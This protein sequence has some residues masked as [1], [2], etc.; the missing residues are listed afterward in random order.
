MRRR[1]DTVY[2]KVSPDFVRGG[3]PG[4]NFVNEGTIQKDSFGLPPKIAWPDGYLNMARGP[5]RFPE[6]VERPRFLIAK[7][8]GRPPRDLEGI[9]PYWIVSTRMKA[10]LR[11]VDPEACEFCPCETVLP[12]GE[13]GPERWLCS[14]TRAFVGAIDV[15]A[16]VN[17]EV[18]FNFDGLP[19]FGR[20]LTTKIQFRP[21]VVGATHLFTVGEMAGSIFCDHDFK[22]ACKTAEL[23]GIRFNSISIS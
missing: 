14:V 9:H 8:F 18:S 4:W 5:W 22:G 2:Y 3:P 13:P 20:T 23:N 12:S 1:R 17:L 11:A 21:E 10:M 15:D 6:Y 7:K 16:S 19:W